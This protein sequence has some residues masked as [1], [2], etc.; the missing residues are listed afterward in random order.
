MRPHE[1]GSRPGEPESTVAI[2]RVDGQ[3][4]RNQSE[5]RSELVGARSSV[6]GVVRNKDPLEEFQ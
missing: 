4:F 3:H 2:H 1:A 5:A 6:K